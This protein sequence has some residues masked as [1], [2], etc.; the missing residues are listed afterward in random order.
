MTKMTIFEAT[1]HLILNF[2]LNFRLTIKSNAN[3]YLSGNTRQVDSNVYFNPRS[4]LYDLHTSAY[5]GE[6]SGFSK[7]N[8]LPLSTADLLIPSCVICG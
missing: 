1:L 6:F 4:R 8:I 3:F 2:I 5:C 7:L